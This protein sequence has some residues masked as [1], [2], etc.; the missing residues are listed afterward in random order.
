[1]TIRAKSL[2]VALPADLRPDSLQRRFP[3]FLEVIALV[4]E[5]GNG[6]ELHL[7]EGRMTFGTLEVSEHLLV[8]GLAL[9]MSRKRK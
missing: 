2:I 6:F 1:M 4:G 8:A 7:L 3:V 9:F 5:P